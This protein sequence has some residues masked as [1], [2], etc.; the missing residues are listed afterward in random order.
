MPVNSKKVF[1]SHI[2]EIGYDDAGGHLHVAYTNGK[3]AIYDGVPPDVAKTVMGSV[4][5][6]TAI[7]QHVRGRFPHRYLEG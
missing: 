1:S 4:S 5:I 7:H 2:N 3:T 6:G